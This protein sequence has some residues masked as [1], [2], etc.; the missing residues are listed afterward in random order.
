VGTALSLA[1]HVWFTLSHGILNEIYYPR[2]DQACTRDFGLI[3]TDGQNFFSE[4]KRQA[5]H[6]VEKL[7]EGL[8]AFRLV[9]TCR[10]D[11]YRI[12][13]LIFSDPD[14]ETVLQV[15]HFT[16]LRNQLED[17]RLYALLAPHLGNHGSGN[18]AWVADYKGQP[19]LLA[20]REGVALALACSPA[21]V[22]RS[23][24]FIGV[25]DSWQDL[26]RHKRMTWFYDR[27]ENGN[28]SLAGEVDLKACNG[29]FILAVSFGSSPEEA[30]YRAH[31]SL[32]EKME[33][34]QES[35]E[36]AWRAWQQTL[37]SLDQEPA[38]GK[39]IYR[40]SAA[41]MRTHE[42]KSFAGGTIAS[43]SIP[44]GFSKGDEDLGGYHLVWPRDLAETAAGLLA[45]GAKA[46]VL[47]ILHYLQDTQEA[48]GHW[49]QN[50]W[51]DGRSYWN[52]IQMDE[53]ALPILAVHLA[54]REKALTENEFVRLWPMLD[55]ACRYLARNG[56]V[57]QQD[58]WEMDPGYSPF[59]LAVEIAALLAAAD[60]V[61]LH[62]DMRLASY[63]EQTA[64]AWYDCLD[65]W[66]YIARSGLDQQLNLHGHYVR[67]ASPEKAEGPSPKTG[68]VPI[69]NRP[70]EQNPGPSKWMVSPDAL[71]LVRYGLRDANDPRIR[72][73]VKAIDAL[74]KVNTPAGPSWRRYTDD[75]Y[76][77]HDDGAPFNGSGRGRAWPLLTGERAHYELAAG[78]RAGAE[79][80]RRAMESFTNAGGLFPEQV[81]DSPDIPQ[82][83]LV[84][85]KPSGSA[86]PLV[87]AHAEYVRLR[88]SLRDNRVFDLPLFTRQRYLVAHTHSP[89]FIWRFN[90]KCRT[91]PPGKI[92]RV[93]TLAPARI[94]WSADNW[95]SVQELELQD[96]GAGIFVADLPTQRLPRRAIVRFT[97][98][99]QEPGH[100]QGEDYV[101]QVE[102]AAPVLG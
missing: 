101:V 17:Y 91:M 6:Q 58:R 48:D 53:T 47:L 16:P 52:G 41:V 60:L 93:E 12:E 36:Q 78:N 8:P 88:R 19:L 30:A 95:R 94:R 102:A 92:L 50:M 59:T 32:L 76:G 38:D 67:I 11:H 7:E 72:D 2:L 33:E 62:R 22:G 89:H 64:D 9:N 46:D 45:A 96:L 39:N 5:I 1:S 82:R 20:Q 84:C 57:T 61:R 80:L 63:L 14:R 100:W 24:G 85:G 55:R 10:Q 65:R 15:I 69:K 97:F 86:M 43:L 74:L 37:L 51:L 3:V 4:E 87:W 28:V 31:A 71:A 70:P 26:A 56:P 68:Y 25:S 77:E 79:Q 49:P 35:Y 27:A 42:A 40:I 44:W 81:W 98:F 99:W 73:T 13:K 21:W 54:W 90:H 34:R 18:T 66:I 23:V 75:V 83:G 29:H